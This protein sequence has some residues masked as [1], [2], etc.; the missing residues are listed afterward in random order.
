MPDPIQYFGEDAERLDEELQLLVVP[1]G[2]LQRTLAQVFDDPWDH[3]TQDQDDDSWFVESRS[4]PVV[5]DNLSPSTDGWDHFAAEDDEQ[6]FTDEAQGISTLNALLCAPDA[7]DHFLTDE[8]D[9]LVVDDFELLQLALLLMSGIAFSS[10]ISYGTITLPT[11]RGVYQYDPRFYN[12]SNAW[13][14]YRTS[15]GGGLY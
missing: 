11:P 2:Y 14:G 1:G 12:G 3:G 13:L 10:S 9:Y 15:S 6:A 8:D 5:L 7:W 4:L